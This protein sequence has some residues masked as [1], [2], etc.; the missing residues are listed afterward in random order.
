[1]ATIVRRYKPDYGGEQIWVAEDIYHPIYA[2]AHITVTDKWIDGVLAQRKAAEDEAKV[3]AMYAEYAAKAA[4][5]VNEVMEV[6][7]TSP[8]YVKKTPVDVEADVR[9]I[10]DPWA[11]LEAVEVHP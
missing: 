5:K 9:A 1:M 7:K 3:D 11:S 2:A 8:D 6:E 10:A 4:A